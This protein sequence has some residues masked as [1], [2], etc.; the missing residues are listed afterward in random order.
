MPRSVL[1]LHD[2]EPAEAYVVASG[3]RYFISA[4][5]VILPGRALPFVGLCAF[6]YGDETLTCVI[7]QITARRCNRTGARD[8]FDITIEAIRTATT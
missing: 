5:S 2:L 6:D 1:R 7:D 8:A 3:T 4:R